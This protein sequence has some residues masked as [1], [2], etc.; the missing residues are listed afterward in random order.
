MVVR[1]MFYFLFKFNI[2]DTLIKIVAFSFFYFSLS[3]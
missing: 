1:I 3:I 2:P